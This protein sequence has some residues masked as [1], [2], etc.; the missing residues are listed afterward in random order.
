LISTQVRLSI[1]IEPGIDDIRCE[2]SSRVEF[3]EMKVIQVGPLWLA[4]LGNTNRTPWHTER[5]YDEPDLTEQID[6]L[7]EIP[8]YI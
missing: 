7:V 6:Q 5:E 3:P 4:S 8:P 1:P 2:A